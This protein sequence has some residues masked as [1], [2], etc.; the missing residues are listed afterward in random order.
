MSDSHGDWNSFVNRLALHIDHVLLAG[1]GAAGDM[2]LLA[3]GQILSV[4]NM[5]CICC[6]FRRSKRGKIRQTLY[7]SV[8]DGFRSQKRDI[9]RTTKCE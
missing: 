6:F 9:A 3:V 7:V 5:H 1:S 2:P 4:R 8:Q